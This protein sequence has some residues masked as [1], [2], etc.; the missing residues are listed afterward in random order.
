MENQITSNENAMRLFFNEDI[1][2]VQDDSV[3][4]RAKTAVG[5][6]VP[7]LEAIEPI[8]SNSDV[9]KAKEVPDVKPEEKTPDLV[10]VVEKTIETRNFK[11]LGG[12]KKSVLI[13]VNDAD[14]DVSTEEGKTLLRNIV[15]AINLTTPDFALVN[16]AQYK[17]AD[18]TEF[19]AFYKPTLMLAFGVSVTDLKLAVSWANE[20]LVYQKTRMIFAPNLH[21]LD[22]DIE[23]KK[24]LWGNLKKV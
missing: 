20:M 16:Y 18:F 4:D 8:I 7:K 22:A 24:L 6:D 23:A 13:L 12:N 15:K 2:L 9:V 5:F 1:F 10:K 17:D 11:H 14:N 21:Q 19:H 3:V